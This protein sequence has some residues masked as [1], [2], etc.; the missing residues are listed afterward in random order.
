MV[1]GRHG[2]AGR[3]SQ[4]RALRGERLYDLRPAH[5]DYADKRTATGSSFRGIMGLLQRYGSLP[6]LTWWQLPHVAGQPR[7]VV[8]LGASGRGVRVIATLK[9]AVR[10]GR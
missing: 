7:R 2:R 10:A 5:H 9:P 3:A 8:L 6:H 1:T 4:G